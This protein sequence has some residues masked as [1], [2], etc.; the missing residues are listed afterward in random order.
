VK[1]ERDSMSETSGLRD[2][3]F[4]RHRGPITCVAAIPGTRRAVTSGYDGA[5]GVVNLDTGRIGLLGY[6]EHLVNRIAVNPSGTLAASCGSD[7]SIMLWDLQRG[8]LAR[9]LHGHADDV[10]DFAFANDGCGISVSRDWRVLVWDLDTGAIV[11]VLDGHERDVLSVACQ[12]GRVYTSGDDMTLRVWDLASGKLKRLW[13]PFKHETDSCAV[14][15]IRGRA[16]LGCDDG[17]LRVFEIDSGE[18]LKEIPAHASGIKR[19][20]ASPSTGALLSAA[21]DQRVLVWNPETFELERELERRAATWERSLNWSSDGSTIL[22]GTFAGTVLAWDAAD[23]RCIAEAGADGRGNAC[24]NDV[25]ANARGDIVTVS[26]DGMLRLGRL[27]AREARWM[28]ERVPDSGSVLMNAVTLDDE[29]GRVI[30]GAHDHRLRIWRLADGSLQDEISIALGEG[31]INSVRVSHQDGSRGDAF[32]ACYSGAVVRVDRNGSIRHRFTAHD[33]AVKSLRL[34]PRQPFGVS[35]AADGTLLSWRFDG[36]PLQR[37]P[38]HM[39]IVDDLDIDPSGRRVASAGR[40]FTVKLHDLESGRLLESFSLGR[41]SPKGV[42]FFDD[43]TVVVTNYWG[44]LFRLDIASGEMIHAQIAENGIS[45]AVRCGEYLAATSY[46]GAIYLVDPRDL[47]VVN[48]LRV[49]WQR[50]R[51]PSWAPA[52]RASRALEPAAA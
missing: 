9:V 39:S 34:H 51:A 50:L 18:L 49:M 8:G 21:Y 45:A 2:E 31:P 37:F 14:D 32:V 26:D 27:T 52:R 22:A 16:I 30:S 15:P 6:H 46:D 35:G 44:E 17:A 28:P 7:Y 19:V 20:A 40:D 4:S 42:C 38:G 24:L 11:R 47:S 36:T 23:G 5:V 10:E 29:F 43:N 1:W 41:K 13:G 25:S 33:G 3:V 48:S 12:G